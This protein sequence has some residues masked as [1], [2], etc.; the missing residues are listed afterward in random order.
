[1][2]GDGFSA[3]RGEPS[4]VE[5]SAAKGMGKGEGGGRAEGH[6]ASTMRRGGGWGGVEEGHVKGD[7]IRK[8]VVLQDD[9]GC[10]R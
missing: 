3:R 2:D 6:A 8:A 10:I 9:G 7:R 4:P 5:H 1:M